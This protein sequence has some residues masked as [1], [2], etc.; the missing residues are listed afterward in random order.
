MSE[1]S[2]TRHR[3]S[4]TSNASNTRSCPLTHYGCH[5]DQEVSKKRFSCVSFFLDYI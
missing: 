4:D 1:R 2:N 3:I 5:E